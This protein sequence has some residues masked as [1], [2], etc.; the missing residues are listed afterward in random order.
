MHLEHEFNPLCG[1][2]NNFGLVES[3]FVWKNCTKICIVN[4][5]AVTDR[6]V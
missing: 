2:L 4:F 3:F 1:M 5:R 6:F